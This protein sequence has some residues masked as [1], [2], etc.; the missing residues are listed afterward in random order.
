[1]KESKSIKLKYNLTAYPRKHHDPK[2]PNKIIIRAGESI[3]VI[4]HPFPKQPNDLLHIFNEQQLEH[5]EQ[6]R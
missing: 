3:E 4:E 2:Q 5:Y 1:M 6:P